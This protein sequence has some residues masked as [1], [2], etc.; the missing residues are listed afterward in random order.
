MLIF[1]LLF[2]YMMIIKLKHTITMERMINCVSGNDFFP[3]CIV[4]YCSFFFFFILFLYQWKERIP[5]LPRDK[6]RNNSLVSEIFLFS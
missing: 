5:L 6:Y 3:E 4:F 1:Y 2:N